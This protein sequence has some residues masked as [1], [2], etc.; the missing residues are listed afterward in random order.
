M[1]AAAKDVHKEVFM[2]VLNLDLVQINNG[3]NSLAYYNMARTMAVK[4]F[5]IQA[6]SVNVEIAAAA[7]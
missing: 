5:T 1:V 7:K 6:L 2:K 3:N 4:S